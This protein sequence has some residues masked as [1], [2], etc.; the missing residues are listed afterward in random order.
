MLTN[1][2]DLA[3]VLLI[4]MPFL[5]FMMIRKNGFP[6]QRTLAGL[7]LVPLFIVLFKTGSRG[8]LLTLVVLSLL[9]FARAPLA[10]KIKLAGAFTLIA[11]V[12]L[13][14]LPQ[15]IRDRYR[16]V[17]TNQTA[18]DESTAQDSTEER[19]QLLLTSLKLTFQHPL[20]GVG[21]GQFQVAATDAARATNSFA[22]WRETHNA[23]TQ[24]SSEE[25]LPAAFFYVAALVF[26]FK[27]LGAIRKIYRVA[28]A[29]LPA[30]SSAGSASQD[31]SKKYD[32]ISA[33]A[34]CLSLS[35]ISFAVFG[36]FSS[37]AYH[38][39][40]PTLAGLVAAFARAA[41]AELSAP[42]I[43]IDRV[44]RPAWARQ[45]AG[46]RPAVTV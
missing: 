19:Y 38:F 41:R 6:V 16:T 35:L 20:V 21:P 18:T 17:Y 28:Q 31:F 46:M 10:T 36:F 3:Q 25:G 27:E 45:G 40:F 32:E 29:S 4:G 2:N 34:F 42:D 33:M 30:V 1:P 5:V 8:G 14:L 13:P 7:C 26:C 37:T 9:S 43:R 15:S 22:H 23:Y 12:C 24:V 44:A 39:F 11:A